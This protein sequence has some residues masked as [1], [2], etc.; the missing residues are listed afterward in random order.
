MDFYV[1]EVGQD[2]LLSGLSESGRM[3]VLLKTFYDEQVEDGDV[4][5]NI[6]FVVSYVDLTEE[7][8]RTLIC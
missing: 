1:Y 7:E 2:L 8:K 5:F 4:E 6:S 3:I